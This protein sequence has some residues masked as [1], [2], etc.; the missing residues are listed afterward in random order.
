MAIRVECGCGRKLKGAD[1]MAGQSVNCPTC[2]KPLAFVAPMSEPEFTLPAP[3]RQAPEIAEPAQ[4][5]ALPP[6]RF[7]ISRRNLVP[8]VAIA[9]LLASFAVRLIWSRLLAVSATDTVMVPRKLSTEE[10]VKNT[11]QSVG[12]LS[13]RAYTGTCFVVC[14][15]IVATNAHVIKSARSADMTVTFHPPRKTRTA[16]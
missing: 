11:E 8:V 12:I 3:A 15:G 9:L 13:D 5:K 2:G 14:P 7:A 10:V 4:E 1:E 16:R 6:E